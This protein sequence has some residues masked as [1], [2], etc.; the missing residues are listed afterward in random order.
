LRI[1]KPEELLLHSS[2]G[3]VFESYVITEIHKRALHYG[4]E[5]DLYFWRD[6][7]GHEVDVILDKVPKPIPLEI[8]SGKTVARDYFKGIDSWRKISGDCQAAAALIYAGDRSFRQKGVTVYSWWN[9]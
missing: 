5:A 2:R 9:F 3:A 6:S 7:A 8:K 1:R 4:R